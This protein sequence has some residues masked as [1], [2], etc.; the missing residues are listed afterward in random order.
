VTWPDRF[1]Y[2]AINNFAAKEAAGEYLIF[3]NNDTE[4][5]EPR[6]IE[7]ML[8]YCQRPDVGICG[9]RLYYPDDRLQHCGI[10]VGIG[11]IAGHICHLEKRD[12]GGYFGRVYKTQDVSAVTAACLMIS[13]RVFE[14]VGGFDESLAVAYN[15]VDLCLKVR[16]KGLLVVY[17]A[18]CVLYHYESLSRGSDEAAVDQ[19][20]HDRQMAEAKILKERWPSIFR[21]G[22]PYFNAN[23]DYDSSDYV[24][25]GTIPPNYSTLEKG[26][27]TAQ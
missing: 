25:K 8:G 17:N 9:A 20:K 15:D 11:G 12:S 14:E 19:A 2:S 3:L 16:D 13:R 7:E 1:N 22:D 6:W 10:V 21:D 5:I 24:L 27:E 26:R 4:V 23:L 18:W